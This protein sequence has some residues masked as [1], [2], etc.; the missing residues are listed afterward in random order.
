MKAG[1][2][3][4]KFKNGDELYRACKIL[5]KNNI[6]YEPAG[7]HIL[8]IKQEIDGMFKDLTIM[9]KGIVTDISELNTEEKK[10]FYRVRH[11]ITPPWLK[12]SH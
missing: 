5:D 2:I 4:V 6:E 10:S 12:Y 7:N 8:V 1:K 9:E 3:Y 11:N